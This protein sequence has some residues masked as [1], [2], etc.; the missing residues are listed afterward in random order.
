MGNRAPEND[1]FAKLLERDGRYRVPGGLEDI[2]NAHLSYLREVVLLCNPQGL[3]CDETPQVPSAPDICEATGGEYLIFDFDL[4]C[5]CYGIWQSSMTSG[6]SPQRDEESLFL[7]GCEVV[8]RD[9]L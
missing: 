8:F 9:A 5:Y 7:G 4:L 3:H 6:K 1:F 2:A